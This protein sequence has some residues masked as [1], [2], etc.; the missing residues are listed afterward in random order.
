MDGRAAGIPA[1]VAPLGRRPEPEVLLDPAG[2]VAQPAVAEQGDLAVADPLEEVAVVRDDD[3]RAGP[4]VEEV[5]ERG[6][7]LDVEVVGRLVEEEHVGLVHE[8][9]GQLQP[10]ALAAGQVADPGLLAGAGEAEPLA[11]AGT[12]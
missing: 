1:G 11:R 4:A 3:E 2:Q 10:P 8:Q 6:E 5:L 7:R 9:P 12:R